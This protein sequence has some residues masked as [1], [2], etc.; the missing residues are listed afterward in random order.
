M[1][2]FSNLKRRRTLGAPPPPTEASTN[3]A[4]PEALTV[5][6]YDGGADISAVTSRSSERALEG[7]IDGRSMRRTNRIVQFATRVTPEFD[8][9]VR[10][11]A[12]EEG[13]LIVEILEKALTAYEHQRRSS[14]QPASS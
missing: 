1:A 6:P 2:D 5:E 8:Q 10:A 7:R 14:R 13:L 3:L 11:I 4:S 12:M 9:R